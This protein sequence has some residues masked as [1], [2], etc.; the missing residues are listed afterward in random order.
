MIN[1]IISTTAPAAG[2]IV[3]ANPANPPNIAISLSNT[4]SQ[5]KE[6]PVVK[7]E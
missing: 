4:D 7:P 2:F 6:K 5:D 1:P 3:S